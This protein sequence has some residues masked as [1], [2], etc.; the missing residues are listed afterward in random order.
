MDP[1][2]RNE[3]VDRRA[4]TDADQDI[5]PYLFKCGQ[6]LIFDINQTVFSRQ[7]HAFGFSQ[8]SLQNEILYVVSD[9][10]L[11]DDRAA[12]HGEHESD[13]N[14]GDRD[15]K[16]EYARKKDKCSQIHQRT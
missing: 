9:A 2:R 14:I 6:H 11:F 4:D 5:D 10:C 12:D 8:R 16:S 15:R 1:F 7:F 3:I 13:N